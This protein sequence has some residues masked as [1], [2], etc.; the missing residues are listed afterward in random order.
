MQIRHLQPP[1]N[2]TP[3]RTLLP[4]LKQL[5]YFFHMLLHVPNCS[6]VQLTSHVSR[7]KLLRGDYVRILCAHDIWIAYTIIIKNNYKAPGAPFQVLWAS[8]PPYG[9]ASED[10]QDR[11]WNNGIDLSLTGIDWWTFF[12]CFIIAWGCILLL[13]TKCLVS[14]STRILT[15]A[16]VLKI[17]WQNSTPTWRRVFTIYDCAYKWEVHETQTICKFDVMMFGFLHGRI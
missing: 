8:A 5:G 7:G 4:W 9:L 16:E 17:S 2:L 6:E 1:N 11:K 15:S 12:L 3:I 13:I 14:C 10:V